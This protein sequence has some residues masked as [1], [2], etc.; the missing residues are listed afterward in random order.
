MLSLAAVS[1][2]A[3]AP[4]PAAAT[5]ARACA[6]PAVQATSLPATIPIELWGNHVFL[7]ACVDGR[8]LDFILD[9]GAGSTSLDLETAKQLGVRLGQTL[10]VGGAGPSRV[11]G[12]RTEGASAAISGTSLTQPVLNAIDLSRLPPI[13]G[14]RMDGILAGDFISRYVV[15]IDYAKRELRVYDRDAFHYDGPGVSVPVTIINAFPHIDA[16]VKLTDGETVRGRMVIDVGASGSLSLTK[17]FV[18]EHRLRERV[19]PTIRRTGGGGVGGATTSDIGRVAALSIG[20]IELSRPIVNLY[21][22]SAG[23]MTRSGSW[24]GNIGGAILRRFTVYFDYRGKRMIFEPN[25]GA[26]DPFEVDMSGVVFRLDDALATIVVENVAPETPGSEAGL[27]R[28][29]VIVSVDGVPGSQQVLGELRDR[30]RRP[31]ERVAFVVRRGS[32]EKK[33]EIVT[34]RMV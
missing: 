34:R 25:A 27:M 9:T 21:G 16:D 23:A 31:G 17:G 20:G 30:L 3:L 13:E 7:K 11:A 15:A 26:H 12:A 29:D 19:G 4:T 24:E 18:D 2:F 8:E 33:I 14:H 28:G 1:A 22:D 10:S 6:P 5:T 32:E